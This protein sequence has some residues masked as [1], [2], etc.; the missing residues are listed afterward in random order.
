VLGHFFIFAKDPSALAFKELP[1]RAVDKPK[2]QAQ[3]IHVSGESQLTARL[4]A[5][6]SR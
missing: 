2:E 4:T 6:R 5:A 3:E 1:D